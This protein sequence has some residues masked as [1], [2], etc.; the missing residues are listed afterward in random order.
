VIAHTVVDTPIGQLVLMGED[1][2][3]TQLEFIDSPRVKCEGTRDDRAFGD[4]RAQLDAYFAGELRQFDFAMDPRGTDFQRRVWDALLRIPYGTTTTYGQLA[5]EL[6]VPRAHRA[7]GAAN[8]R[9]PIAIVIPCHRLI[10]ASGSLT[11]YGGGLDRKRWLLD[12]EGAHGN[13]R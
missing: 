10:G 11:G 4:A 7:V 8:G 2:R 6:G 3:L 12:L 1:N 13:G 5:A 9:N